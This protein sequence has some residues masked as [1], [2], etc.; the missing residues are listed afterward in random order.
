MR[1]I[2]LEPLSSRGTRWKSHEY[3]VG[4]EKCVQNMVKEYEEKRQLARPTCR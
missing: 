4:E 2:L 3:S 1:H